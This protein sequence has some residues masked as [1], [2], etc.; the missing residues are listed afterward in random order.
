LRCVSHRVQ[1]GD[2]ISEIDKILLCDAQTSGGLLIALPENEAKKL[3]KELRQS[4]VAEAVIVG[5][6]VK[7]KSKKLIVILP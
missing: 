4:G 5:R 7:D 1:W 3:E 6:F 2:G